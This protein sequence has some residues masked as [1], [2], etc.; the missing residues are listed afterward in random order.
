MFCTHISKTVLRCVE[1][2]RARNLDLRSLLQCTSADRHKHQPSLHIIRK[3]TRVRMLHRPLHVG[4]HDVNHAVHTEI[5][6]LG[7]QLGRSC[8][9]TVKSEPLF[10]Y[11]RRKATTW[12]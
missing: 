2:Q 6:N 9:L 3:C 1:L 11:H 4:A 8:A 5:A 7:V 12:D 10:M